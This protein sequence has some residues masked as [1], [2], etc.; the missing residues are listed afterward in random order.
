[1]PAVAA[2]QRISRSP[3]LPGYL[4][5]R[6]FDKA[7][8]SRVFAPEPLLETP[9]EEGRSY[10]PDE[11]T[12]EHAKR[13]HYAAYRARKART[14]A[15]RARWFN[16]YLGLRDRIV[17]GNRKLI[18]RA[19]QRR[20][21]RQSQT[22]DMIGDCHIVLIQAVAAFNPWLSIRFSTYAYTCLIRAL[23]RSARRLA[24]DRL[25]SAMS[26]EMFPEGEPGDRLP[27]EAPYSSHS[28][29]IEE[30]LHATHPLLTDREKKIIARRFSLTEGKA[31]ETLEQ[32]GEAMGLSKERV[33][34]VQ[35]SALVKLRQALVFSTRV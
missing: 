9:L 21:A 8:A 23:C 1:M 24:S 13:M 5:C 33:R 6:D 35:A 18:Y 2:T 19:V 32:V 11:A 14:R 25:A 16:A 10:M 17:L 26:F 20:M 34:Q 30:F 28:M 12:R 29:R 4:Y 3:E 31:G 22:D 7:D 27:E 15:D